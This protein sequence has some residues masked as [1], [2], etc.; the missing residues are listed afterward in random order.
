[1]EAANQTSDPHRGH[2]ASAV[3]QEGE[4]RSHRRQ[5][6]RRFGCPSGVREE[7]IIPPQVA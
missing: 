7:N 3:G 2:G 6:G 5:T 4:S 1:M